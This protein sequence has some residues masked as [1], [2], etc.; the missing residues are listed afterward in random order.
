MSYNRPDVDFD[1]DIDINVDADIDLTWDIDFCKDVDV[2]IYVDSD[3][4]IK[5]NL[6]QVNIDA[7]A[8]GDNSLVEIDMAVLTTDYLSHASVSVIAAV[9]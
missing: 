6:T 5:G 4:D 8:Y 7:E 3:V 1:K 9:D 2:D